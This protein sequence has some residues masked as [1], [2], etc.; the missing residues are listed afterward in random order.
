[1]NVSTF[2][3]TVFCLVDDWQKSSASAGSDPELHDSE[4][5]TIV[6]W[7]HPSPRTTQ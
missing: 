7:A 1:M 2:I 4:A 6:S 5:S 3:L